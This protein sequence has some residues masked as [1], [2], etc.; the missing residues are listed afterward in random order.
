MCWTIA[1]KEVNDS[2][3]H[4]TSTKRARASAELVTIPLNTHATEVVLD[5]PGFSATFDLLDNSIGHVA[6]LQCFNILRLNSNPTRR[7]TSMEVD[8]PD[9]ALESA[10]VL[11]I[12][13]LELENY[14]KSL[15]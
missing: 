4:C 10:T 9:F 11:L 12:H 5:R 14:V 15:H 6:E 1:W 2:G 7:I 3:S 13:N 8:D